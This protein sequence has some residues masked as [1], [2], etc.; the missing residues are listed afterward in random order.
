MPGAAAPAPPAL[1]TSHTV[2][3][4][5]PPSQ[6]T[7]RS[8][9]LLLPA[10]SPVLVSLGVRPGELSEPR[11][12]AVCSSSPLC[13]AFRAQDTPQVLQ[14]DDPGGIGSPSGLPSPYL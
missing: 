14:P 11:L 1:S 13:W 10:L 5:A 9:A 6:E 4:E 3:P 12:E 2:S 7:S 8:R